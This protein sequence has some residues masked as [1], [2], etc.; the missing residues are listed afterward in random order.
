MA[1]GRFASVTIA[2]CPATTHG[3]RDA[4][5]VLA[6][7]A[8]CVVWMIALAT[9]TGVVRGQ[10][11]HAELV[12]TPIGFTMVDVRLAIRYPRQLSPIVTSAFV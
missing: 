4:A 6:W 7:K 12:V 5:R 10:H 8:V 3:I 9:E 1:V 11:R 2:S